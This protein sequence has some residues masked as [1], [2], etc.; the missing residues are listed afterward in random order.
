HWIM[1]AKQ[2]KTRISRLEKTINISAEQ[3]RML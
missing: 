2:E 1:A 3:K